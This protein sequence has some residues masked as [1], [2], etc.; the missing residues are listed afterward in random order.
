MN[1]PAPLDSNK[2][3]LV[4]LAAGMGSRYGGLKQLEGFG[5]NGELIL[6]YSVH[7]AMAAGFGRLIFVVRSEI[8]TLFRSQV[9]SRYEGRLPVFYVCQDAPA[10]QPDPHLALPGRTKPWGTGH[11]VWCTREVVDRP[12][13]V[14]N[15]DDFYGADGF[16]KLA[17]F[18]QENVARA[19][20][21]VAFQLDRT[22]SEHGSVS[23]GICEVTEEGRLLAVRECREIQRD[24]TGQL[25]GREESGEPRIFSGTEW[26]S[27]NLWGFSPR[28]F[29]A[30]TEGF[31]SFMA[32]RGH[33][34]G[35]EYYLPHAVDG[36]ANHPDWE[37]RAV[38]SRDHWTGVTHPADREPV[39]AFLRDLA[40]ADNYAALS[41]MFY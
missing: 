16:Q 27:M 35:A 26:A 10:H 4:I 25:T 8:E 29:S 38:L 11:A 37:I 39:R 23:R 6:D 3:D 32:E 5:P 17:V 21:L 19:I 30:L 41:Q 12:F 1:L 9:G 22:L 34:P 18:F 40:E 24:E 36:L 20:L 28:F 33:S 7:D 14:I 2:P 31:D 13:A 15:A